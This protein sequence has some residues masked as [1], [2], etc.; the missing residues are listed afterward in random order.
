MCRWC[1]V[2]R[3]RPNLTE[4][5]NWEGVSQSQNNTM[6]PTELILTTAAW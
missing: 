1:S 6:R 5:A 4:D 3:T 2:P